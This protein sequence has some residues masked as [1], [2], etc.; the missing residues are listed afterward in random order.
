MMFVSLQIE[1]YIEACFGGATVEMVL[2]LD[3]HELSETGFPPCC[4][5]RECLCC[6]LYT[7]LYETRILG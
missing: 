7:P 4:L 1:Y 5:S 3:P 2:S 6:A